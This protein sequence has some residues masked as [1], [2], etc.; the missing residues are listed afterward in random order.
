MSWGPV[1]GGLEGLARLVDTGGGDARDA[2]VC[3]PLSLGEAEEADECSLSVDDERVWVTC[4]S[5]LGV[6]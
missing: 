1:V 5:S 2:G 3:A 4:I 6:H